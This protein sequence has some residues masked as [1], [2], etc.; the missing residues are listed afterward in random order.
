MWEFIGSLIELILTVWSTDSEMRGGLTSGSDWDRSSR[1][2][3]AKLCGGLILLL[4]LLGL[5]LNW[6]LS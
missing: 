2:F 6:L 5:F 3:V 1:W 4:V